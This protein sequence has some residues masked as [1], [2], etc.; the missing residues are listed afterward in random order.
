MRMSARKNKNDW[1]FRI[2]NSLRAFTLTELI[3]TITIVS[4]VAAFAIPNYQKA[5]LKTRERVAIL[6]LMTIHGANEIYRARS[7]NVYVPGPIANLAGINTALSINIIDND[8]TYSYARPTATTYTGTAAWAGGNN[9]TVG[10]NQNPVTAANPY[11][12]AGNC[13]TL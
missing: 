8:M 10:I 1:N 13:P 12:A 4:M 6:H 5:V 2:R 7:G 3:V 11:C 9:F